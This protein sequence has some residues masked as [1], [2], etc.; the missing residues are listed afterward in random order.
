MSLQY[1]K[2][3]FSTE[4]FSTS[5][6]ITQNNI[7][8]TLKPNIGQLIKKIAVERKRE[9][10]IIITLSIIFFSFILIFNFF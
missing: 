9:K 7:N 1:K 2:N 10:K 8:Q 6:I 3:N 5:H 4:S